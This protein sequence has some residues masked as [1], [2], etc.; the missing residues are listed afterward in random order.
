MARTP[1]QQNGGFTLVEVIVSLVVLAAGLLGLAQLHW[2]SHRVGTE[3]MQRVAAHTQAVD[4]GERM[5][6]DLS[7]PLS[8]VPAWQATHEGSMPGWTGSAAPSAMDPSLYTITIEWTSPRA[9]DP[10]RHEY[11]VRLPIVA[12]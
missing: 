2:F 6:L 7:N 3:S 5:W 9:G 1:S 10:P 8:V 12:P 11:S 4:L